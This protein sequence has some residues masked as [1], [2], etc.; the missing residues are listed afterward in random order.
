MH[1]VAKEVAATFSK[2]CLVGHQSH[3]RLQYSCWVQAESGLRGEQRADHPQGAHEQGLAR[4]LAVL[5]VFA[6]LTL[7][8]PP[9]HGLVPHLGAFV[10]GFWL[11][12]VPRGGSVGR[13]RRLRGLVRFRE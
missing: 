4:N 1:W 12:R 7:A 8:A 6:V 10:L 5:V 9:R 13:G 11:V 3:G 2:V